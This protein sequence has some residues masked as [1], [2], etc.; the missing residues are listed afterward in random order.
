MVKKSA[1]CQIFY[2]RKMV[3]VRFVVA[4]VKL[5]K[6]HSHAPKSTQKRNLGRRGG[7][8]F[9]WDSYPPPS[10]VSNNV[11]SIAIGLARITVATGCASDHS[12]TRTV[13]AVSTGCPDH[14]GAGSQPKGKK[15]FF[16]VFSL[17]HSGRKSFNWRRRNSGTF[18]HWQTAGL[19]M[20]KILAS[21]LCDPASLISSCLVMA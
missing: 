4:N 13:C 7:F 12:T 11:T 17:N 3:C 18:F 10:R 8:S 2:Q 1:K 21:S 16:H 9:R 20:P 6:V 15:C 14:C 19:E 5:V